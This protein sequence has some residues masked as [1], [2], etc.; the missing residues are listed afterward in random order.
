MKLGEIILTEAPLASYGRNYAGPR[1]GPNNIGFPNGDTVKQL[2]SALLD[3]KF[4]FK[5]SPLIHSK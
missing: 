1:L 5:D 2:K 4:I 3:I